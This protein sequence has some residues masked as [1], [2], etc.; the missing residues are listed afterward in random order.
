MN[1]FHHVVQAEVMFRNALIKCTIMRRH[2]HISGCFDI[3]WYDLIPAKVKLLCR[4][5]S[6]VLLDMQCV[7]VCSRGFIGPFFYFTLL[8]RRL[9]G[10]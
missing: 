1:P 8:Y 10:P 5:S 2:K 7:C 4:L 6:V 3:I 9:W